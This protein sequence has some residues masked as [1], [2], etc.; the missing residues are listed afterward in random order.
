MNVQTISMAKIFPPSHDVRKSHDLEKIFELA[1]SIRTIGLINPIHV[2]PLGDKFEVIAGNRRYMAME[3]LQAVECP[4][5]IIDRK[6]GSDTAIKL[7]ENIFREDL[8]PVEEATEVARMH[9]IELLPFTTIALI[10]KK[11]VAWVR[12]RYD[13]DHAASGLKDL[14]HEKQIPLSVAKILSRITDAAALEWHA[15]QA[16]IN[17]C[18]AAMA[19]V[20]VNH[21]Q[22]A[23]WK[24]PTPEELAELRAR[25]KPP[26]VPQ[27]SCTSCYVQM[28]L[29]TV[30]QAYLCPN[31]TMMINRLGVARR[32]QEEEEQYATSRNVSDNE[33]DEPNKQR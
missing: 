31:C 5:I 16:A 15:Q 13:F 10:W 27:I 6:D 22:A 29:D 21:Y 1:E 2:R 9:D 3:Q 30:T 20:W 7:H 32:Q 33:N 14:V 8:T 25:H 18:T 23:P 12:D 11:S 19:Q 24:L 4:C 17:G 28:P 26:P